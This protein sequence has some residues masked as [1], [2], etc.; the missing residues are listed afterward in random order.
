MK[1]AASRPRPPLPSAASG[2]SVDQVVEV[3]VERLQR[4]AHRFHEAEIAHGVAHQAA[5][6]EFEREVVD[7]LV[8]GPPGLPGR[9]HPLV[10]DAVAHG[11]D[12]GVQPVIRPR[13]DR[14]LADRIGQPLEDFGLRG[15]RP[16]GRGAPALGRRIRSAVAACSNPICM[17]MYSPRSSHSRTPTARAKGPTTDAWPSRLGGRRGS[18]SW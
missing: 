16:S 5:D 2:S 15:R 9:L 6:Q 14:I 4:L 1:Q 11:E 18:A 17:T 12:G 7:A 13:D 3:D 8:R 10:D